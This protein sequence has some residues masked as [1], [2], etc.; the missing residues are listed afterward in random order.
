MSTP[1]LNVP[2]DEKLSVRIDAWRREQPDLPPK[3]TAAR[4]LISQALDLWEAK[5]TLPARAVRHEARR[6]E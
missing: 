5:A 4:R 3:A 6:S 1:R 2:V